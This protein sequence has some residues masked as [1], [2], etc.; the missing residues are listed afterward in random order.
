MFPSHWL[1][2][3][4]EHSALG[5]HVEPPPDPGSSILPFAHLG[6]AFLTY[7]ATA[8]SASVN[9]LLKKFTFHSLKLFTF[10]DIFIVCFAL[11]L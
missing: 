5:P 2:L 9:I 1:S 6:E 3:C 7:I 10:K 11:R 8:Q 4:L